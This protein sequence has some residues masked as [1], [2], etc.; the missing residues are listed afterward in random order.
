MLHFPIR[1]EADAFGWVIAVLLAAVSIGVLASLTNSTVGALWGLLLLI[2]AS[3]AGFRAW[4]ARMGAERRRL[5][6]VAEGRLDP[7][8]VLEQFGEAWMGVRLDVLVVVPSTA[9]DDAIAAQDEIQGVEISLQAVK[10]AGATPTARI[11]EAEP[12]DVAAQ[13]QREF[14]P[15]EVIVATLVEGSKW[16]EIDFQ[17]A[18][19]A[20]TTLTCLPL[21]RL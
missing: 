21:A 2:W 4:R 13:A 17:K 1:S 9:G 8:A 10:E 12:T 6:V 18:L 7:A 14:D 5:L 20:G 16:G 3:V 11:V 19:G 15:A